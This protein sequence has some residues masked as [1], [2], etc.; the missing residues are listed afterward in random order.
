MTVP[1]K[2]RAVG[3]NHVALEVGNIDEALEFYGKIF[4]FKLR[5][6]SETSAFIDLGDQFLALQQGRRQ[7]PDD[8]RHFGL[9]VDDRDAVREALTREGVQVL[10][11][12]FLDFLDPWGNRI[13]IVPY[14]NIQFSKTDAV[15]RG[16]GMTD[17]EKNESARKELAEKGMG[18]A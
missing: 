1:R 16:M 5:S 15:L 2:A 11:G 18:P 4:D 7:S 3:F 6:K 9:V 14:D 13:E 8:G 12:R 17:L 10:P